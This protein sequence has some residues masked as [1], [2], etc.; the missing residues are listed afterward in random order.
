LS[1]HKSWCRSNYYS[2]TTRRPFQCNCRNDVFVFGSNEAG[3]HGAGAALHAYHFFGAVLGQGFGLMG[4]SFGIPTKD[5]N[6]RPLPLSKIDSYVT[7][8]IAQANADPHRIFK[9]TRIGCG[10]AG[11][12]D[13][14][15]ASMFIY[16][17]PNCL[18]DTRWERW[19][20][21]KLFW[22]THA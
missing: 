9:V 19:L 7:R 22:G 13:E 1:E 18:F 20:P 11:Y 17:P 5:R 10:L 14:Q 6:L 4:N 2:T 12:T 21:T 8:F 15:M 3:I 16:A